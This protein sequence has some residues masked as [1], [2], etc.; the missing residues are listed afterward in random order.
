MLNVECK[1]LTGV[2]LDLGFSGR[3]GAGMVVGMAKQKLAKATL[4]GQVIGAILRPMPTPYRNKGR[5]T[6]DF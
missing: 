3:A 5:E 2:M 1:G 6:P 4:S